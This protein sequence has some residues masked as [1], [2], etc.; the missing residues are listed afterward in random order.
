ME[1]LPM[2]EAY[3]VKGSTLLTKIE[4]VND[5]FGEGAKDQLM[6]ELSKREFPSIFETGWIDFN[7]Y[8]D[9]LEL[10]AKS[11]LGGD[12]SR[13]TEAG[14][15][16]AKQGLGSTYKVFVSGADFIDFLKHIS[17]LHKMFYSHGR[18]EVVLTKG[19]R[20]CKILHRDKPVYATPDLYVAAGFYQGAGRLH[21]LRHVITRFERDSKGIVFDLRW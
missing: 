12:V 8:V 16:S 3:Q 7:W 21:G 10:I 19:Q 18:T 4:F 2:S 11:F 5:R 6:E 14:E 1:E 15:Y 20:G 13:L 17:Q 9:L